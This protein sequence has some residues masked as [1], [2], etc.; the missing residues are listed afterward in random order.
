MAVAFL[1][2]CP[3]LPAIIYQSGDAGVNALATSP[4]AAAA[5]AV[6]ANASNDYNLRT[7]NPGGVAYAL[8]G[9]AKRDA[10]GEGLRN[11]VTGELSGPAG[12][13]GGRERVQS[14]PLL[15]MLEPDVRVRIIEE[16]IEAYP[17]QCA[18]PYSENSD[19]F[20][21]GTECGYYR[22]GGYRIQCYPQDIRPQW[23]IYYRKTH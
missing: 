1:I 19:G 6:A 4:Y 8:P 17:G 18:C 7:P 15:P 12:Q 3:A 16:S 2:F 21:C 14:G 11:P 5:A 20:Q 9:E 23:Y 10:G 13:L 22:P